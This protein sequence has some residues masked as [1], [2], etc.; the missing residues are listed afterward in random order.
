MVSI[1]FLFCQLASRIGVFTFPEESHPDTFSNANT[2]TPIFKTTVVLVHHN[3][4]YHNV[5]LHS[6]VKTQ[7]TEC[8]RKFALEKVN[9]ITPPDLPICVMTLHI[10]TPTSLLF[11]V[12]VY[13]TKEVLSQSHVVEGWDDLHLFAGLEL[14]IGEVFGDYSSHASFRHGVY[15]RSVLLVRNSGMLD[16]GTEWNGV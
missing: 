3:R 13:S 4:G 2:L 7:Y 5:A 15:C 1:N 11:T 9:I 16:G 10:K 12:G 14:D 8:K 6:P